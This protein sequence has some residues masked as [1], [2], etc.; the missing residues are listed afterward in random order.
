MMHGQTYFKFTEKALKVRH[1][2]TAVEFS[3]TICILMP[4]TSFTYMAIF[5]FCNCSVIPPLSFV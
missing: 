2:H 1:V 3:D 4:S 5:L